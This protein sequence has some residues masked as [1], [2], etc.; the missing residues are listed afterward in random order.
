M[1]FFGNFGLRHRPAVEA[2]RLGQME[3][4]DVLSF[5]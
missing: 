2:H 1:N 5:L 3:F 4:I